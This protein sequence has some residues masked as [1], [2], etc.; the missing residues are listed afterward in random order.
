MAIGTW[1]TY[2]ELYTT[3]I[4]KHNLI[5]RIPPMHQ[6]YIETSPVSLLE[7]KRDRGQTSLAKL[8]SSLHINIFYLIEAKNSTPLVRNP[9]APAHILRCIGLSKGT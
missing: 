5:S 1:L 4:S 7:F 2:Q 6:W 3:E 9:N 8:I